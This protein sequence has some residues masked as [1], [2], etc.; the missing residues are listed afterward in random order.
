VPKTRALHTTA[1]IK[2]AKVK[3]S[4]SYMNK[5]TTLTLGL[6]LTLPKPQPVTSFAQWKDLYSYE[7]GPK[8]HTGYQ[9]PKPKKAKKGEEQPEPTEEEKAAALREE[10]DV[11]VLSATRKNN[12]A[13]LAAQKAAV[14]LT[15]LGSPVNIAISPAQG[16]MFLLDG[17][18]PELEAGVEEEEP[19]EEGALA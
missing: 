17:A 9:Q 8:S 18:L 1:I 10:Y 19:E 6:E 12:R 5:G 2:D 14:L 11:Y 3:T 13:L 4:D 15:L 16:E 7:G